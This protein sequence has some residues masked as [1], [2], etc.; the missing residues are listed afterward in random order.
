M[1]IC[2]EVEEHALE[3]LPVVC[4]VLLGLAE[5]EEAWLLL[6]LDIPKFPRLMR[7]STRFNFKQLRPVLAAEGLPHQGPWVLDELVLS[8]LYLALRFF[9][10]NYL[11]QQAHAIV[12]ALLSQFHAVLAY[13]TFDILLRAGE[14]VRLAL[15]LC[16]VLITVRALNWPV[17]ARPHVLCEVLDLQAHLAVAAGLYDEGTHGF[18]KQLLL[19]GEARVAQRP[20]FALGRLVG[21]AHLVALDVPMADYVFA[22]AAPVLALCP[23]LLKEQVVGWLQGHKLNVAAAEGALLLA[24]VS[25][26]TAYDGVALAALQGAHGDLVADE[27]IYH[28]Y[29]LFNATTVLYS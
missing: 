9:L 3:W 15:I 22:A 7:L 2:R 20:S 6:F 23:D 24:G 27:A 16:D 11:L 26:L 1:I 25:A 19:Q 28:L 5:A 14:F 21:A 13:I 8:L 18:M 17:G 4:L 10:T 12:G 29:V